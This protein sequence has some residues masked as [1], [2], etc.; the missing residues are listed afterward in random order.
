[1][2]FIE[3]YVWNCLYWA[4]YLPLSL[5]LWL[6]TGTGDL[7][8]IILVG[9]LMSAILTL[10]CLFQEGVLW[11][12][13]MEPATILT[14]E[15]YQREL[16]QLQPTEKIVPVEKPKRKYARKKQPEPKPLEVNQNAQEEKPRTNPATPAPDPI[17]AEPEP[18]MHTD[19]DLGKLDADDDDI[20]S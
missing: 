15:E 8:G 20:V 14:E 1:M 18:Q 7:L 12:E 4:F 6:I 9:I 19:V 13:E 11:E 17:G 5:L 2:K 16:A 3:I 10:I